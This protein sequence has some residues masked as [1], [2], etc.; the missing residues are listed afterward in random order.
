MRRRD[1]VRLAGAAAGWP[2]AVR[3]QQPATPVIGFLSSRTAEQGQYLVVAVR[4]GLAEVGYVEGQNVTIEYRWADGHIE[5]LPALAAD[6]VRSRVGVIIAGGTPQPAIAA[7]S[8][9]PIV[10]TTGLDPIPYGLVTSLNRP[11]R[12]ATGITFYSG[13]L[14]GKQI[15]LLREMAPSVAMIGLLVKPDSASAGP[16]TANAREAARGIGQE[17]QILDAKSEGDFEAAFALLSR[18]RNPGLVISVD[19]YFDSRAEQLVGLAARYAI[20][21]IYNLRE[22]AQAGGLMSYGASITDTYRLAGTYAGR[23]L[24]G[25]Q[26]SELPVQLPTKFELIVNLKT[27]RALGLDVSPMLLARA[28]EVI[29]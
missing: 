18:R 13:A 23:I 19:P 29:E 28:D 9:I 7:T 24:G 17:I 10:F 20:P 8:T 3:A 6:L 15:E 27:A 1:F 2:L 4:R 16:Q 14:G 25:A 12:N 26:P 11:D 5:R 22:Y 21:A